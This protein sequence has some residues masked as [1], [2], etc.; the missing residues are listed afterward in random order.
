MTLEGPGLYLMRYKDYR[1]FFSLIS[2]EQERVLL[3]DDIVR[4]EELFRTDIM[5]ELLQKAIE[6]K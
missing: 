5:N 6:R 2:A 3:L 4:R 1:V